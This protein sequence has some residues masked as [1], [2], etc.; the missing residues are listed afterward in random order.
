MVDF[1][2]ALLAVIALPLILFGAYFAI[3]APGD[4]QTGM[5]VCPAW[6]IGIRCGLVSLVLSFSCELK[7]IKIGI[8]VCALIALSAGAWSYVA[9]VQYERD[10]SERHNQGN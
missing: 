3:L 6:L 8:W 2:A 10:W 7:A 9:S 1:I 5:F 4:G